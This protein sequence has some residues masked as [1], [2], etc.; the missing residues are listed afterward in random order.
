MHFQDSSSSSWYRETTFADIKEFYDK[1]IHP[2]TID[3]NDQNVYENV[4]HNGQ[5]V[6]VFHI[7]EGVQK[8]AERTK[9]TSIVDI[10]AITSI[11]R[12]GPLSAGVDK[13]YIRAVQDPDE[14]D[15]LNN[16]VQDITEETY[17]F[18]IFQEQ[19]ARLAHELGDGITMDEANLL[20]KI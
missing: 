15:Y 7:E 10:S 17:G 4:F 3:L 13:V 14:I 11:Y 12:P 20:R 1:N 16:T 18:L 19:I 2:D 8:L 9:P 5:W 6:G